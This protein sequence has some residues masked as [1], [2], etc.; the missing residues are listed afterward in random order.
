LGA[1]KKGD[2]FGFDVNS[3]MGVDVIDFEGDGVGRRD[4]WTK[5]FP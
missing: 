3:G 1:F 4:D 2:V 5:E